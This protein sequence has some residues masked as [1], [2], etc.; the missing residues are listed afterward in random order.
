MY[1]PASSTSA[2]VCGPTHEIEPVPALAILT[3]SKSTRS[4]VLVVL[5]ETFTSSSLNDAKP[6]PE[7][8]TIK[9]MSSLFNP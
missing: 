7:T 6:V 2:S 9:I 3:P 5:F 8:A 4:N 1:I